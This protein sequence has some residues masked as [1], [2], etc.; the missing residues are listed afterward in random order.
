MLFLWMV[1]GFLLVFNLSGKLMV[2]FSFP[3]DICL[4]RGTKRKMTQ[5][6]LLE[7]NFCSPSKVQI[8]SPKRVHLG[9]T[10]CDENIGR[11]GIIKFTDFGGA[12]EDKGSF[13]ASP[14]C[15]KPVI[16]YLCKNTVSDDNI[17]DNCNTNSF[18]IKNE[19]LDSDTSLLFD[20]ISGVLLETFIVGRK[21]SEEKEIN[22]GE[23]IV[24]VRDPQNVKDPNAVK[25]HFH[26]LLVQ[27]VFWF[28]LQISS[29]V[30]Q[31]H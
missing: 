16:D 18:S 4:S 5:R 8:L 1:F 23:S 24:L 6:T 14:P 15:S 11:N 9:L 29:I 19:V 12:E 27:F 31:R 17:D 22:I 3:P 2:P 7:M 10:D 25:V 30:V 13:S 28:S 26:F 21:F 20:D